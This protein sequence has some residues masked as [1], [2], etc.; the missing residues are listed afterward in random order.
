MIERSYLLECLVDT[1]GDFVIGRSR[2]NAVVTRE[3]SQVR[4][5]VS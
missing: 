1:H 5:G 3:S 4:K 2:G